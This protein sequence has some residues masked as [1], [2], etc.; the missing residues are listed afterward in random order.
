M[1]LPVARW[2]DIVFV[3]GI[4]G[5]RVGAD[6]AMRDII[7]VIGRRVGMVGCC[8]PYWACVWHGCGIINLSA[9]AVDWVPY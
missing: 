7:M 6:M 9:R 2:N 3:G 8:C 4:C 1:P 5:I